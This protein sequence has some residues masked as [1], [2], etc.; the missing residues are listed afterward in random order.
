MG[1][2]VFKGM[3]WYLFNLDEKLFNVDLEVEEYKEFR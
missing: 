2:Y 3:V 1:F